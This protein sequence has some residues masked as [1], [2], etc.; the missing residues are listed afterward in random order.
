MW[1]QFLTHPLLT[2][3]GQRLHINFYTKIILALCFM[4]GN[5][6]ELSAQEAVI[7]IYNPSDPLPW[8][9]AVISILLLLI[10][11]GVLIYV[12]R[13]SIGQEV[14]VGQGKLD[15]IQDNYSRKIRKEYN[16][17]HE[18]LDK[19]IKEVRQKFSLVI[20]KVRNLLTTL[21]PEQLF[22]AISE[23]IEEDL[24]VNRYI[25][26]LL[27]PVKNELY[28]FRWSGYSDDI[29]NVLYIPMDH[30]HLLTYSL[31]S[32]QTIYRF[33]AL[34]DLT[35][36]KLVDRKPVSNTLVSIP[37]CVADRNFGVIHVESYADGHTELEE[38]EIRFLSTLP[39]FLGNAIANA[40]I[41]VQTREELT[42]AKETSEL[43]IA[44]KK[45]LKE[46]FS[47]YT[48][49]ELV[50]NLLKNPAQVDLG[51]VNKEAAILFTDIAGF[52]NFSS[53]LT[54]K[55]VVLYM[56]EYL[57]RMTEVILDYQGEIDKFIGDA[58]MARFGVL[59]DIAYPGRNAV[60][61]AC[62]MLEELDKL[63]SEWAA[64][65]IQNFN[66]RVGIACGEVLA[67]NLG[68][69]R[70]QEFTVMGS[71]VNLASRLESLNKEYGSKILIDENTFKQLPVG[72]KSLKR[73]NVMIRGLSEAQ[74]VYEIQEYV[75][76]P[77]VVSITQKIQKLDSGTSDEPTSELKVPKGPVSGIGKGNDKL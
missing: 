70:R 4:A 27:D 74:T 73:D 25:L 63:H 49:A 37:I 52:T 64:R 2:H 34:T 5:L 71:T 41:F 3:K 38:D 56:N 50:D 12:V 7:K 48:S 65:G 15:K 31:K 53:K 77:K 11:V 10:V 17:K 60:E 8:V 55:E 54:P 1:L 20:M 14:R 26:F 68:S 33:K 62:A 42:S 22:A 72:I 75:S 43:E 13:S 19:K 18:M 24:G 59:S 23:M 67:G 45:K 32:K 35:I 16:A 29:Q 46:I 58:I 36:K 51:G 76:R 44:E 21:N 28:P 66:I 40:D 47:R 6:P 39:T 57:S 30:P 9:I 61:A 69:K